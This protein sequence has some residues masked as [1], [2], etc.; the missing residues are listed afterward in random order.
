MDRRMEGH[1]FWVCPSWEMGRAWLQLK[2]VV[3]H[4]C[5]MPN[6]LK[7]EQG[8]PSWTEVVLSA[9]RENRVETRR[10]DK[11]KMIFELIIY[12]KVCSLNT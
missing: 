10:E 12:D 11:S 3:P 1:R 2:G 4:L 5:T 8:V 7:V 6:L 9:E